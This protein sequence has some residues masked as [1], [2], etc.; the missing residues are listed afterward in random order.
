MAIFDDVA[1][2]VI[3]GRIL[4]IG[5]H[6]DGKINISVASNRYDKKAKD[7]R[8]AVL[9]NVMCF[10]NCAESVAR[11][12]KVKDKVIVHGSIVGAKNGS[13]GDVWIQSFASS[14]VISNW[15]GQEEL[16]INQDPG[17]YIDKSITTDHC[18]DLDEIPF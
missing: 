11:N 9:F 16:K 8:S 1:G 4:H 7:N 13:K 12:C 10:N 2:I 14:V 17:T 5:E 6:K 15:K 18:A 3:S